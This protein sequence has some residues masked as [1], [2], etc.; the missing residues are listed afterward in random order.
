M[1][2]DLYAG[3]LADSIRRSEVVTAAA[4]EKV[5]SNSPKLK[6]VRKAFSSEFL[7]VIAEIKRASPSKGDLATI[8]DASALAFEYETAGASVISVLTEE[9]KFK[10]SLE[11][12]ASVSKSITIPVLRKDFIASEYQILEAKAHGA[13]VIL[14][15]VAGLNQERLV[16]LLQYANDLGLEVLVE[17]HSDEE[18]KR[19]ID[20]GSWLIGVNARDL[21]TFETDRDLFGRISHLAPVGVT[22]VA[23]SAVRDVSDV[24]AYAEQG[25]DA[26]LIG[27]AL[28]TGDHKKLIAE[29]STV[30]KIRL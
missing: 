30:S 27:E 18:F 12:L 26:V 21:T 1:L 25:A 10:G 13:D 15:I 7:S 23:E 29:F 22:L 9:R 19:A 5:I 16:E 4:L 6:D 28:V 24:Q 14:L 17:T 8:L 2:E 11:D 20:T 3:S